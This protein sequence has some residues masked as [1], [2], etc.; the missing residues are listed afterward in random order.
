MKNYFLIKSINTN[1]IIIFNKL[2]KYGKRCRITRNKIENVP[3]I[4]QQRCKDAKTID[5]INFDSQL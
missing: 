1:L 4:I 3:I 5:W 2:K